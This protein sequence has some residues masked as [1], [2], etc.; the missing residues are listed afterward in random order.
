MI[1]LG[2]TGLYFF[3]QLQRTSIGPLAGVL[4]ADYGITAS[5][6]GLITSAFFLTYGMS[7]VFFGLA[8]DRYT[9][10]RVVLYTT[11]LAVLSSFLFALSPRFEVVIASRILL[12]IGFAGVFIG[13]LEATSRVYDSSSYGRV[14]GVLS[15]CGNAGSLVGMI[16]P[17]L[18]LGIGVGWRSTFIGVGVACAVVYGLFLIFGRGEEIVLKDK[19]NLPL[20]IP[21]SIFMIA[22]YFT[23]PVSYGVYVG[24]VT[25]I[26]K[27][28][29]DIYSWGRIISGSMTALLAVSM[30]IGSPLMG[31]LVDKY[32][33]GEN[34]FLGSF[35]LTSVCLAI[36]LFSVY[37]QNPFLSL[38]SATIGSLFLSG[39]TIWPVII[40]ATKVGA[41]IGWI[42]SLINAFTF[43]GAFGFPYIMGWVID[44]F[45]P[46]IVGAERIYPVSSYFSC[47]LLCFVM[48]VIASFASLVLRRKR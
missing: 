6:V 44:W 28:L 47:F 13:G 22:M 4:M 8:I 18:L 10:R 48:M 40:R 38:I 41:N 34:I 17:N 7:Q 14:V 36:L 9:P 19:Q 33:K 12:G 3:S 37:V 5:G 15:G 23:L 46:S 35:S 25:W 32:R 2:Y 21:H 1:L 45:P 42:F 20:R 30:I 24:L 16:L 11:V 26:P 31:Y 39:F 29:F 43:V 27:Y